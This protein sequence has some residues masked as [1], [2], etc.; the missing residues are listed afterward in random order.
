M[1]QVI[2]I[3]LIGMQV[4]AFG[5]EFKEI[6]ESISN[7][8]HH[9]HGKVKIIQGK[10][11][12]YY[13]TSKGNAFKSLSLR[14]KSKTLLIEKKWFNSLAASD[15]IVIVVT[16]KNVSYLSMSGQGSI[17]TASKM[18]GG[19]ISLS[20]NGSGKI[21]LEGLN[22]ENIDISL[23][24]SGLIILKDLDAK[25]MYTRVNGSGQLNI[26]GSVSTKS[27]LRLSGSGKVMFVGNVPVLNC[28]VNGSGDLDALNYKTNSAVINISGSGD[29]RINTEK[30]KAKINGSGNVYYIGSPSQE[31]TKSGKGSLVKLN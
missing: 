28:V 30:I 20:N 18:T 11:S 27:D 4:L 1:K 19:E 3:A 15:S 9:T 14:V 2:I 5:Q 31:L 26:Q 29:V 23:S 13:I 10:K 6:P 24:G 12:G 25:M 16:L 21:L 8:A 17:E 22:Y 7:V